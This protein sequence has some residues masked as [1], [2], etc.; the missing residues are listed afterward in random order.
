[1]GLTDLQKAFLEGFKC[2]WE[3]WNWEWPFEGDKDEKIWEEI[4][5]YCNNK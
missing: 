3:G 2:S 1:M 4:K 5:D